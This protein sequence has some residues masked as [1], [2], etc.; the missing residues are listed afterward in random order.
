VSAGAGDLGLVGQA[1]VEPFGFG[2]AA[3]RDSADNAAPHGTARRW[4]KDNP[5]DAPDSDV[6][7]TAE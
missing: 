7:E 1:L 3:T 6:E 4:G 5:H 2:N